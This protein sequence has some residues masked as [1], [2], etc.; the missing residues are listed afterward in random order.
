MEIILALIAIIA[1]GALI[2]VN[3]EAR[4]L[5]INKDGK[6]DLNDA[7]TAVTNTL[8]AVK[9]SANINRDGKITVA[10]VK[11][12]VKKPAVKKKPAAKKADTSKKAAQPSR[13][14]KPKAK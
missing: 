1:V 11:A 3:R 4:S 7:K 2:Y 12:A 5:D 9:E 10:E 13:G 6:V 14:R 8:A